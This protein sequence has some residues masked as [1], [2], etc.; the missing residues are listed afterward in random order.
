MGLQL[1]QGVCLA[2]L[3]VAYGI[4]WVTTP[5]AERRTF[6]WQALAIAL[7]AWLAEDTAIVAYRYYS[8]PPDLWWLKLH[9]VPALV[10]AIWPVVILSS[11]A[12]ILRL[13]PSLS[14]LRLALVVG[15]A[16]TIDASLMETIA[17]D[18]GLWHWSEGGYLGVPLMGMLGWGAYAVAIVWALDFRPR[19]FALP[20]WTAPLLALAGTH[21]LIIAMWWGGLR[22]FA[23]GELPVSLVW[24]AVALGLLGAFE[25]YRRRQASRLIST[26]LALTRMLAAAVFVILLAFSDSAHSWA[27]WAHFGA[28]A[29]PYLATVDWRSFGTQSIMPP[30]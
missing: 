27:L 5:P 4:M 20:V 10:I 30:G 8:Y 15:V 29:L 13:W 17:A 12:V 14:G 1:F 25:I 26:S 7:G 6:L 28:V 11:R 19:G 9:E 16:V 2:V 22:F 23:R 24:A 21:L 18:A 3:C